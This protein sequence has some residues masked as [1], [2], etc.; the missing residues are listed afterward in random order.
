MVVEGLEVQRPVEVQ[1]ALR[2]DDVAQRA[3]VVHLGAAHPRVVGVVGGVAVQPV[4]D[5]QLVQRQLVGGGERL[6]VVEGLAPVQDALLHGVLPGG[7]ALG[8]EVLVDGRIGLLNLGAGGRLEVHVQVLRQVPAHLEVAVP[9]ELLVERQR[10]VGVLGVLEVALLQ[11][12]VVARQVAVEGDG[13]R[14]VVQPEGFREIEPLRLA[15]ELLERLP[16]LVDG[17]VVVRQSAVP[18]VNV[19]VDGG[20]AGGVAVAVAVGERE[21]GGVV[22]HGVALVLDA[23]ADVLQREVAR[24]LTADGYRLHGVALVVAHGVEGLVEFQVGVQRV[25]LRPHLVFR[26][27]VVQGHAHL[28]LVGE[29]LAQFEVGRH[30]VCHA[31]LVRAL[32]DVLLEPAEAVGHVAA[33]KVDGAEV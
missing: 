11:L 22:G 26:H 7:V 10:Q 31:V 16:R 1:V 3:A 27:A 19:L 21:V 5:G 9:E 28:G 15:L 12:A 8:V 24:Q 13:L 23:H 20:L 6:L 4:E 32:H 30:R 2:G 18:A 29:E 25:V 33:D 17:R 14:Q